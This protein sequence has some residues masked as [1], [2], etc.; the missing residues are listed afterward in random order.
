MNDEAQ[1]I[2]AAV[3]LL[4]ML[5]LLLAPFLLFFIY[6]FYQTGKRKR[7]RD[8]IQRTQQQWLA[9]RVCIP[10]RYASEPRFKAWFKIF[11][12]EG[13]GILVTSPGNVMF[14]GELLSGTPLNLRFANGQAEIRWLGKCPWPNGAVSWFQFSVA[15]QNHFFTSETGA[16]II[17]SNNTTKAAY[18]EAQRGLA[19]SVT[20]NA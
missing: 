17:G 5:F 4:A 7:I 12:W 20:G 10:V 6:V 1:T 16:F 9:G 18:D 2:V 19:G 13:S 3:A 14:L 15:G 8:Q 11:P